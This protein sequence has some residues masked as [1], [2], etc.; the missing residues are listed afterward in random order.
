MRGLC[1]LLCLVLAACSGADGAVGPAGPAGS[2][3]RFDAAGV[4][5]STGRA[6]VA[7]PAASVV[8]GRLPLVSCFTSDDGASW[9]AVAQ[10]P[11]GSGTY[12]GVTG[13]PSS[14][15]VAFVNGF[16]GWRYQVI[17]AW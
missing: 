12:C 1:V 5:T 14:P 11:A 13:L 16:T 2:L 4:F 8:N 10:V 3:N 9:L 17:V 7:L 6:T 15:T